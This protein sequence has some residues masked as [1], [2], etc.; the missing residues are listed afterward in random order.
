MN[1]F[2]K[3][4]LALMLLGGIGFA[5]MLRFASAPA[6]PPPGLSAP[7]PV[8]PAALV[9]PVAGVKPAALV[10]SF[11]DP[12]GGGRIHGAID[13]MAPGGTPVLAAAGGTIEKL[14]ESRLGGHTLYMRSPDRRWV[15]YYA[16]LDRYAD[17]VREGMY[18]PAGAA[19]AAVGATGDANEQGPH[20]HFEVKRMAL[21]ESWWR[22]REIDPYP[23]LGG[24]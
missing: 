7:A 11:N 6:P 8:M 4:L 1:R 12:R 22:G 14:F 21:G 2:G 10:E 3:L 24:R 15:Y 20:L 17:G 23:L 19:I 5:A 16:H 13:I 18:V 9:M